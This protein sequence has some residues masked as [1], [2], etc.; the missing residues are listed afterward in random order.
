MFSISHYSEY[1]STPYRNQNSRCVSPF[2]PSTLPTY[3]SP[4]K[5]EILSED[6]KPDI[7]TSD[8]SSDSS[9]LKCLEKSVENSLNISAPGSPT[10]NTSSDAAN[11]DCTQT[12]DYS[13][14]SLNSHGRIKTVKCKHC[15][16]VFNTKLE[17]WNH[18]RDHIKP[19]RVLECNK[20]P[21]VTEYKHH[22]EYHLR[23]H[24]GEK[25]YK[26]KKC[27]YRCVNKSMLNSHMK[28]HS[29]IYQ[30][31]CSN[32]HYSSKYCHSLKIHLRKYRHQP[33]MVLNPD[34]TPNPLPIIDV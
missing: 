7:S 8:L 18:Q 1:R 15:Q 27:D 31:R 2:D 30:Y 23:N 16:A 3:P 29:N 34:G 28:S 10:Q 14:P 26:C 11:E 17:F 21:F 24:G 32:C 9:A 5:E 33:A 6:E 20:C 12:E 4:I 19:D 13:V 25:S 22:M